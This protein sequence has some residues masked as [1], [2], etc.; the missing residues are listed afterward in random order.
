MP[1]E[2][3]ARSG[4]GIASSAR[5]LAAASDDEVLAQAAEVRAEMLAC[6]TTTVEAK[7]GYGLSREGELRLVR[8]AREVGDRVTGLFAHSIPAG[9]DAAG[10]MDEVDA[11]AAEARRRRA[12]HLRRVGRLPQRG[13]RAAGRDRAPRGG[14]AARP[15]GAVQRQPVGA[16]RAGRRRAVGRPPR[17]PAP[18]RRRAA[19]RRRVRRRAAPGRRVP[20]RRGARPRPRAGRCRRDLRARHR[21]QSRHLAG[22]LAAGGHRPGGA[23][24]RLDGA[25]GAGRLHAQRR[26]GAR[27]WTTAA[28]SRSASAPTSSSST[29]WS[30]T[31]RT[32][33]ATTRSPR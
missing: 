31:S 27:D 13:P 22:R 17:L 9:Y 32:A 3:I 15:R 8:L 18:G 11:L 2:E 23:P 12:R 26:V 21:L 19:G 28:R 30:S 16:G 14:A 10:W 20:R 5:A 7:T 25:R 29:G 1:Y 33:S 4:G 6:G 24:L